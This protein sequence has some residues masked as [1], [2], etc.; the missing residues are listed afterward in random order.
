MSGAALI[1]KA[2]RNFFIDGGEKRNFFNEWF[3]VV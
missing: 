2:Y 3:K 1:I